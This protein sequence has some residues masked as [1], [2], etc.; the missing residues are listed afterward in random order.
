MF[1]YL[2]TTGWIFDISLFIMWELDQSIQPS[3]C[4]VFINNDVFFLR[5]FFCAFLLRLS[6]IFFHRIFGL[7][8]FL[9]N[10]QQNT[11]AHALGTA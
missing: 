10:L 4:I 7:F 3:I 5:R 2:V 1:F 11:S 8:F 6:Y 9:G